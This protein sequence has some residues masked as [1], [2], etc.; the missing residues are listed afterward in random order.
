[1]YWLEFGAGRGAGVR[2]ATHLYHPF[3]S[4]QFRFAC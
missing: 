3:C 4:F 1:M 2:Q